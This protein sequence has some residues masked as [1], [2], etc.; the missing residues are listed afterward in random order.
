MVPRLVVDTSVCVDLSNGGL[1]ETALNLPYAL[2]L[3]D[4]LRKEL[5]DPNGDDL[6]DLGYQEVHFGIEAVIHAE[7][8]SLKYSK[9][10]AEDIFALTYAKLNDCVLL[11]N[12]DELRK[13]ALHES[14][15]V[16]GILWLL[17]ELVAAGF[18]PG[19]VAADALQKI[20]NSGGWLPEQECQRRLNKWRERW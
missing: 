3:P 2:L 6:V 16:H 15:K 7:E 14:V 18:L 11:T 20:L 19:P 12:D 17:D 9:A 4:I 8:L 1:L 5:K 13:A 10:S